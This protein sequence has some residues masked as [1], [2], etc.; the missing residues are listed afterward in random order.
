[1]IIGSPNS[2]DADRSK[3]TA[4]THYAMPAIDFEKIMKHE[5][6]A[7]MVLFSLPSWVAH[8]STN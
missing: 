4:L 7:V 5:K 3:K 6:L 2:G 1:M 8:R